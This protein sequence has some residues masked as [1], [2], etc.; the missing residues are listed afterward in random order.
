M[1]AAIYR[2]AND[3]GGGG[4]DDSGALPH[5]PAAGPVAIKNLAG[6]PSVLQSSKGKSKASRVAICTPMQTLLCLVT[7]RSAAL[8]CSTT[9]KHTCC[10]SAHIHEPSRP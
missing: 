5:K 7:I 3:G 6:K 8:R 10:F 4:A 2:T 9:Q 1:H